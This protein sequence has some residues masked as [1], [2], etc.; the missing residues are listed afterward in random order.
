MPIMLKSKT[1]MPKFRDVIR[2]FMRKAA[3][4]L[5]TASL[6]FLLRPTLPYI[7]QAAQ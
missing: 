4:L 7:V 2:P 3:S 5:K 6:K 1:E